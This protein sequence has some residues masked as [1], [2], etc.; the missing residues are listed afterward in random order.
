MNVEVVVV[1]AVPSGQNDGRVIAHKANVGDHVRRQGL[2]ET[3]AIVAG[4]FAIA[5]G[6]ESGCLRQVRHVAIVADI[7]A[8]EGRSGTPNQQPQGVSLL[9]QSSM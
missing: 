9:P 7:P 1:E 3:L 4:K 5:G 6:R 8:K 2:S